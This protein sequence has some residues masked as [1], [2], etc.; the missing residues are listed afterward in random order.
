MSV[1]I[2]GKEYITVAERLKL[3]EKD[4]LKIETVVL[5]Q[6]PVVIQAI[7]CLKDG[8]IAT[9]IS[10]A[11]PNKVLEKQSPYEI[12]ETSALGR[13]LGFLGYGIVEGIAMADEIAKVDPTED[14]PSQ[15]KG[16]HFCKLHNKPLKERVNKD[17]GKYFDHRWAIKVGDKE[18]WQMCDGIKVKSQT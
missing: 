9:G 10:A 3:A 8:R 15:V 2:H 18:V 12:A 7:V 14:W 4:I 11:N 13:A 1:N 5:Y 16:D 17:G 6:E